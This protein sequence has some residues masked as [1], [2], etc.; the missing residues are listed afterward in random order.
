MGMN[1]HERPDKQIIIT[2]LALLEHL[3]LF[4]VQYKWME[5][6]TNTELQH[7]THFKSP[8]NKKTQISIY[9][10]WTKGNQQQAVQIRLNVLNGHL[11]NEFVLNLIIW[12]ELK[13]KAL[14]RYVINI[15]FIRTSS[16]YQQ[17]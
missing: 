8:T 6:A 16:T 1:I 5:T 4:C 2:A 7:S 10:D 17:G 12:D 13:V 11:M 14:M 3:T 15:I 9:G